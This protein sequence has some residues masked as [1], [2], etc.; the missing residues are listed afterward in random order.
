[1][2]RPMAVAGGTSSFSLQICTSTIA[3]PWSRFM[4]MMPETAHVVEV[5]RSVFT[6]WREGA[7]RLCA[8]AAPILWIG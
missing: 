5:S 7:R 6:P 2:H 4:A 3:S 8:V 1:M